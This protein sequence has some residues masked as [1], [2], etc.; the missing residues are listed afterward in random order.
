MVAIGWFWQFF[1]K[2]EPRDE[3]EEMVQAMIK[4]AVKKV[5]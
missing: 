5:G 1:V 3:A 2:R 4:E